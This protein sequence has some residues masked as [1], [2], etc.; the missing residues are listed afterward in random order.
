MA[1][2]GMSNSPFAEWIEEELKPK[3]FTPLTFDKFSGKTDPISHL[4]QFRKNMSLKTTNEA[5]MCKLFVKT[6][7]GS[8]LAWFIQLPGRLITG[9]EDRG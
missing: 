2:R 4:M 3:D 6:L 8:A 9:F 7:V 5:L 1:I